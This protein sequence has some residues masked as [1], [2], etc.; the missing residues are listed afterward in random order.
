M[1]RATTNQSRMPAVY[2][3]GTIR[4]MPGQPA[5]TGRHAPRHWPRVAIFWMVDYR[6][7]GM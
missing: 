7:Q 4:R 2:P 3:S 6:N 1:N 5:P